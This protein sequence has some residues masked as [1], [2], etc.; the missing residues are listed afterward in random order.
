MD[1]ADYKMPHYRTQWQCVTL[2]T[3]AYLAHICPHTI[4]LYQSRSIL[5]DTSMS[6]LYKQIGKQNV[7]VNLLSV[8]NNITNRNIH[9]ELIVG[10]LVNYNMLP[11]GRFQV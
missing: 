2:S 11:T 4:S 9:W 8:F 5:T 10:L 1:T 7:N 3:T 6:P